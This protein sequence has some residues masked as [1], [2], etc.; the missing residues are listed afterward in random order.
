[1]AAV[2]LSEYLYVINP[3]FFRAASI[4]FMPKLCVRLFPVLTVCSSK[5]HAHAEVVCTPFFR[6]YCMLHIQFCS[7][8]W[9][10]GGSV[11]LDVYLFVYFKEA[12][13]YCVE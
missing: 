2:Q 12:R 7:A 10:C 9:L 4:T 8:F 5:Y 6:P 3:S 1:M 11:I 13:I